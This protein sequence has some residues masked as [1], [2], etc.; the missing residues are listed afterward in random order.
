VEDFN[1]AVTKYLSGDEPQ[2]DVVFIDCRNFYESRI[3]SF[4]LLNTSPFILQFT[5]QW[6]FYKLL[7]FMFHSLIY[8]SKIKQMVIVGSELCQCRRWRVHLQ[9]ILTI[10]IYRSTHIMKFVCACVCVS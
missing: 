9:F 2:D 5:L 6:S 4:P 3:V 10:V 1:E 7:L 8:M